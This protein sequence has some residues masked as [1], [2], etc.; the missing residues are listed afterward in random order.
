VLPSG[1]SV[2]GRALHARFRGDPGAALRIMVVG[3]VHGNEPAGIRI[4][5]AL[6]TAALP[7]G[8]AL[9]LVR[10]G[11][12][13]GHAA[14]ARVNAHGVD[15]NRN[16]PRGW[17]PSARGTGNYGGPRPL[18]EPESRFLAGVV[19]AARPKIT[20]WFHQPFGLVDL[21]G[22]STRL[23]RRFARLIG[24]PA[25]RLGPL[26]GT[27]TRWENHRFGGTTSFVCELPAGH[28]SRHRARQVARAVLAL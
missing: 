27:A 26:P 20:I 22:G 21:S 16:F 3:S 24:L 12:P 28:I 8:V 7:P 19:E 18:S 25:R 13:D 9:I 1:H 2:Q 23:E 14:D 5:R 10:D 6:E 17:R 15:L 11:N 4:V